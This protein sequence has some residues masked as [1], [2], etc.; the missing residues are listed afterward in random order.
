M[1]ALDIASTLSIIAFLFFG[2]TCLCTRHMVEEFE[3]YGLARARVLTGVLQLAGA[4]GLLVGRVWP[5]LVVPAATGL[6]LLMLLG[7]LTRMR[8]RDPFLHMTPALVL[9]L[10][11][12]F[13]AYRSVE[14]P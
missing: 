10:L 13:I 4:L 5:W 8:I 3:R 14:A 2:I 7:V 12:A 1:T 9:L 11:N 6:S